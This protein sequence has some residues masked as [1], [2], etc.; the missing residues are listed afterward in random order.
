MRSRSKRHQKYNN[1]KVLKDGRLFDSK[2]EMRMYV[3]LK[4]LQEEGKIK[5]LQCQ[6]K[7]ELQPRFEILKRGV[8]RVNRPITYSPDF[9]FF[10]N[11]EDRVRV[12]DAKGART[13]IY[14]LKKKLFEWRFK[15]EGLYI[16]NT[17]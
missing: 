11:R 8:K 13:D 12:L 1:T 7:Y 9:V 6:V 16:E 15:D 3:V 5:D 2:K 14:L 17:L 4:R 10:D